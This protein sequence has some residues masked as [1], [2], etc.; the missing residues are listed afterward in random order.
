MKTVEKPGQKI[1]TYTAKVKS[2][3]RAD[4]AVVVI[5][6][7]TAEL[8]AELAPMTFL[9]QNQLVFNPNDEV[10]VKGYE[11]T[12]DGRKILV[13]TE[14]TPKGRSVVRFRGDD[15][16]PVWA[17]ATTGQ[18]EEIRDVTGAVTVVETVD[19][20]DGRLVTIKSD[21][22]ERVI[23]LGPGEYLTKHKYEL[24]PGETIAVKGYEVDR[25]GKRIFLATEVRKGD[26]VWKFRRADRTPLWE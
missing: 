24:K 21:T 14:V 18:R 4:P 12:R 25:S 5:K 23:A 22:G 17:K 9:E 3:E 20:P 7:D 8:P 13:V 26:N 1:V 6:T 15:M 2:F 11:T 16:Q 10:V 19:T